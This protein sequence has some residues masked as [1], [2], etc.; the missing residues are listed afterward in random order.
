MR[1]ALAAGAP[2]RELVLVHDAARPF[3]PVAAAREALVGLLAVNRDGVVDLAVD[4][5]RGEIADRPGAVDLVDPTGAV[6][7]RAAADGLERYAER[8]QEH[9]RLKRAMG[10]AE[11]ANAGDVADSPY[12][13]GIYQRLETQINASGLYQVVATNTLLREPGGA[14]FITSIDIERILKA[15]AFDFEASASHGLILDVENLSQ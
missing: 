11:S 15:A 5:A 9:P 3:F 14:T 12:R 8:L 4:A 10:A 6:E 7:L 1:R 2:D 13:D